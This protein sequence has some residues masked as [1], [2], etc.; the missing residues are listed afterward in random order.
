MRIVQRENC[1]F[2]LLLLLLLFC[3]DDDAGRE[4]M[5]QAGGV[6]EGFTSRDLNEFSDQDS[7][8]KQ[9]SRGQLFFCSRAYI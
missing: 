7:G 5:M 4:V 3:C 6:V 2:G 9:A 1:R 8:K